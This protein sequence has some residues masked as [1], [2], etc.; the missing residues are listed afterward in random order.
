MKTVKL[1]DIHFTESK[2][3]DMILAAGGFGGIVLDFSFRKRWR[4]TL[5]DYLLDGGLRRGTTEPRI[6]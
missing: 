3:I 5:P 6:I 1:A 2:P 4:T